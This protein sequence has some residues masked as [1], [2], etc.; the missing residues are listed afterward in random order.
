MN[1]R[2]V[3]VEVV[4]VEQDTVV[5]NILATIV[6]GE[7]GDAIS[8]T[9]GFMKPLQSRDYCAHWVHSLRENTSC[10]KAFCR[11]LE[12]EHVILSLPPRP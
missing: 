5:V 3:V 10:R 2:V 12:P 9:L 8:V 4:T 7:L 11:I 6:L 1:V